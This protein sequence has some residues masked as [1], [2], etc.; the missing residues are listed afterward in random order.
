MSDTK[1]QKSA[2]APAMIVA[3]QYVLQAL[4]YKGY[5]HNIYIGSAISC[6]TVNQR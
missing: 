5:S 3:S 1:S 4:I 2:E 6:G